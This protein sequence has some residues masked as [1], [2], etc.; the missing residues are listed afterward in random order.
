MIEVKLQRQDSRLIVMENPKPPD[1]AQIDTELAQLSE[2]VLSL[3]KDC[4]NDPNLL[5][6]LLRTLEMLHRQVRLELFEP[7]LPNTRHSLYTFLKDMEERGGWPYI[8]RSKIQYLCANLLNAEAKEAK[9]QG[10]NSEQELKNS[11]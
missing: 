5:L 6:G 7:S 10:D 1:K 11:V 9:P 2:L 3:A 4:Q 8:Q